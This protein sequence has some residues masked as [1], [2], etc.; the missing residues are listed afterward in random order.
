MVRRPELLHGFRVLDNA[1][2]GCGS[3]DAGT[4]QL[5]ATVAS[6]AAG[7]RYYQ[8]HTTKRAAQVERA[9][10]FE[11]DPLFTESERSA[12][13]LARDAALVPNATTPDHFNS[14][15]EHFS[16]EQIVE[17]MWSTGEI[18][19]ILLSRLEVISED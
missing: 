10:G 11:D 4:E 9:Y 7:C 2:L 16:E 3:V 18:D 17:I 8:A 1:I 14:L 12:L 5:V 13:R 15:R 6:N 19:W